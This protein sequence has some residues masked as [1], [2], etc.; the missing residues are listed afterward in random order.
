MVY[1]ILTGSLD[2]ILL[3]FFTLHLFIFS[4]FTLKAVID[5]SYARLYNNEQQE[6]SQLC[7]SLNVH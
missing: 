5:Y 1:P 4:Y 2:F 7:N 3:L 6:K